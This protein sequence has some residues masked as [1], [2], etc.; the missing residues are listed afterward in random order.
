MAEPRFSDMCRVTVSEDNMAAMLFIEPP[1]NGIAY[2]VDELTSFLKNKGVYGGIILSA[3]DYM[4]KE[5]IYNTDY[6]VAKGQEPVEGSDGYYEMLIDYQTNRTPVIRSDGSVDYQSM[7]EINTV[8]CGDELIKYHRPVQGVNGV[9]VRGRSLRA[10]PC[11]DL[12]PIKGTGFEFNSETGIYTAAISGKVEYDGRTLRVSEVY[13]LFQDLDLVTG[14]IDFKG[15][16]IVKGNVLSGTYI[17]ATKSVT[18]A[19]NIESATIIAGGDVTLKKGMQGGNKARVTSGGDVYANFLEFTKVEA[20]GKVEANIIMNSTIEAGTDV[21]VSGKK[22][23]IIGGTTY[24]VGKIS[25][26]YLGNTA[27]HK[28]VASVGVTKAV[29][30]KYK[31]LTSRISVLN[32]D[33]EKLES[34]IEEVSKS[35]FSGEA[36]ELKLAKLSQLN[37]KLTRNQELVA[38]MKEEID[39]LHDLIKVGE[40]ASISVANTAYLGACVNI[41][42]YEIEL[43]RDYS[44]VTF[45]KGF[46]GDG[47]DIIEG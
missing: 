7:Q 26:N 45:K 47:I 10:K 29:R 46:G 16:V 8:A 12:A 36:S 31:S 4:T 38:K 23:A 3:L 28:T 5:N 42:A 33:I 32:G 43:D 1:S 34:D 9:D 24:A 19:G 11:K 41:D 15:D 21:I 13:E 18:I 39:K 22:G 44:S 6:L 2:S 14:K 17:R 25:T 30:D 27:G 20:K 37:R 40:N 35:K